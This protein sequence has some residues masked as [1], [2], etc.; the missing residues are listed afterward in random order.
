MAIK[1]FLIY[2]DIIFKRF[3]FNSKAVFE[4]TRSPASRVDVL[5]LTSP[6]CQSSNGQ[7]GAMRNP[8]MNSKTEIP[9]W[10]IKSLDFNHSTG[11]QM[12]RLN[13]GCIRLNFGQSDK[14]L[15]KSYYTPSLI[16]AQG[17]M[18]NQGW[19]QMGWWGWLPSHAYRPGSG[20]G[21]Q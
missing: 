15:V 14:C 13:Y 2:V 1:C 18:S 20:G 3:F 4:I 10:L 21:G 17:L 7:E 12:M 9:I 11:P 5:H 16:R 6:P 8:C 19:R